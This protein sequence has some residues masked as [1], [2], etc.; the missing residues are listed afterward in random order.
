MQITPRPK[1][2]KRLE[3]KAFI[4]FLKTMSCIYQ[5]NHCGPANQPHHDRTGYGDGKGAGS[6]RPDDYRA[7]RTC[8]TCHASLHTTIGPRYREMTTKI[9]REAICRDKV[10]NLLVWAKMRGWPMD[11][12]YEV[13][14][15]A[16][17]DWVAE[18]KI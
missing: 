6:T 9:G 10:K 12:I 4:D 15:D 17:I 5:I 16:I 1:P 3:D 11:E 14:L 7:I 18:G 8:S 2:R 13:I